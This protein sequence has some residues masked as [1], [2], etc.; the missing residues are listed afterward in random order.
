MSLRATQTW[1]ETVEFLRLEGMFLHAITAKANMAALLGLE[2]RFL[3]RAK[4]QSET[5]EFLRLGQMF[6]YATH[7]Q[8]DMA[9]FIELA[10]IS[11]R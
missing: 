11:L 7:K 2:K 8:D 5:A 4:T 6:L 9:E 1:A 10:S 3:R